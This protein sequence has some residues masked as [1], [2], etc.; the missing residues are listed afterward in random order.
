MTLFEIRTGEIRRTAE[1]L[2]KLR[3]EDVE[4]IRKI[5]SLVL[6]LEEIWKGES[7]KAFVS[8]FMSDQDRINDF[9]KMMQ[10]YITIINSASEKADDLDMELNRLVAK[11]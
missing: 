10:K 9:H 11:I 4:T 3:Q 6:S 8:R 7:E 2:E 5:R 1:Q